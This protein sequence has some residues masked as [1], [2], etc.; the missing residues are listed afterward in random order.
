MNRE[1]KIEKREGQ[2]VWMMERSNEKKEKEKR[3]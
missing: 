2:G 3:R 1:R